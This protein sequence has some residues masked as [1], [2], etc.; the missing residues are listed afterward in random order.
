MDERRT[1]EE[2]YRRRIV[3]VRDSNPKRPGRPILPF[4]YTRAE[5]RSLAGVDNSQQHREL[6]AL[7]S[8]VRRWTK[9]GGKPASASRERLSPLERARRM[10]LGLADEDL[11]ELIERLH[12]EQQRRRGATGG[13]RG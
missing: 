6:P 13:T 4:G 8:A 11:Q 7:G 10:A 12:E 1:G 5:A 9:T 2:G 3:A